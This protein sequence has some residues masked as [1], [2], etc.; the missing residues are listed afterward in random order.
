MFRAIKIRLLLFSWGKPQHPYVRGSKAAGAPYHPVPGITEDIGQRQYVLRW[1]SAGQLQYRCRTA[2]S[3]RT[4]SRWLVLCNSLMCSTEKISCR[5]IS[6]QTALIYSTRSFSNR[7]CHEIVALL[8]ASVISLF[9]TIIL[10]LQ[11]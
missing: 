10:S 5:C 9:T 7:V 2:R 1:F 11:Y 4:V 6:K 3:K 8:G